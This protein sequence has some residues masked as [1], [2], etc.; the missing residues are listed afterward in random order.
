MAET[1][2]VHLNEDILGLS[3]VDAAY[4]PSNIANQE[5]GGYSRNI[6]TA[7][8]SKENNEHHH[9]RIQ[10]AVTDA[11]SKH[12]IQSM[13]KTL[14]VNPP[15]GVEVEGGDE[16]E[17]EPDFSKGGS[18]LGKVAVFFEEPTV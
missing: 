5:A 11:P 17:P 13:T 8:D 14:G 10:D 16:P 3:A 2:K 7:V 12:P 1:P 4:T 18:T 6:A 9:I 15:A